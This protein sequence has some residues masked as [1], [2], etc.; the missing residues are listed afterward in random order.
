MEDIKQ[1]LE[2]YKAG[3]VAQEEII[4]RLIRKP[5][6]EHL[7]GRFDT[8]REART[9]IPEAIL[10]EGKDPQA[11][12]QIMRTYYERGQQLI[13]TRV[14]APIWEAL[15]E[16]CEVLYIDRVARIAAT[17]APVEAPDRGQVLVISAGTLDKPVALEASTM[18]ALLG[19]PVETVFDV[20]VAGLNRLLPELYRLDRVSI[21]IVVAG[22]D[23]ALPS[24]IGGLAKQPIIA[25]PTSVGYGASFQGI[26]PLLTML[27]TCAPGVSVMNIDNG[28][29]AAVMA[30]KI[31]QLIARA[32]QA[33]R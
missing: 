1:L 26:A 30:T 5:Y 19:N 9:G 23:G 17:Q 6:E 13:A 4:D 2:R 18:C 29:G 3:E 10:A 12:A 24:V 22:M 16:L 11:V 15:G 8:D 25:V 7:I 20:G 33:A 31:N 32:T 14:T 21:I 28:F 27:N